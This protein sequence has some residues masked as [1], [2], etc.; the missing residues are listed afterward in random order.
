MKK[1]L[2]MMLTVA[3]VFSMVGCG[4]NNQ[5]NNSQPSTEVQNTEEA[6]A[7]VLGEGATQFLFTVVDKDG[8]ETSF[9]IHTDKEIVGEALLELEL[10]AGED[11]EYGLFVK[12]VNGITAD[13]NEDQT[14]WAFYVNGE[15]ATSGVDTTPIE[16]GMTYTFKVE[17]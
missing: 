8:N 17:K 13:Y 6:Q 4:G 2:C 5:G 3:M 10:I 14:Y 12:T 16:E 9:E 1:L 7:N 11:S 15:Y